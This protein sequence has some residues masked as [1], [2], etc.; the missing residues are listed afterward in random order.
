ME[1]FHKKM[2][3]DVS[4]GGGPTSH[5]IK[6]WST[7]MQAHIRKAWPVV[8]AHRN[9]SGIYACPLVFFFV[10]FIQHYS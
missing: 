4:M 10:F 3:L 5:V 9:A 1:K 8:M 7:Q 2:D 6:K